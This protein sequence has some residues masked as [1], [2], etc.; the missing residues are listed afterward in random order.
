MSKHSTGHKPRRRGSSD[1]ALNTIM[2][3][4]IVA[5]L[6]LGVWAVSGKVAS[7]LANKTD[8]TDT[9][10]QQQT[11][12]TAADAEGKTVAEFL[13]EY[14]LDAQLPAETAMQDVYPTMTVENVAKMNQLSTEEFLEQYGLN[15]KVDGAANWGE[16]QNSIPVGKY[17]GS[18][19]TWQTVKSTYGLSDDISS[20]TPFSEV[21]PLLEA[22][23]AQQAEAAAQA[24]AAPQESAPAASEAPTATPAN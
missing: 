18:E 21:E 7:N 20:D 5:V 22:A 12:Q 9:S 24:S 14:G 23:A 4:V 2:V 1:F 3:V 11:V 10:T 13:S 15:G 19:E 17:F 8:S 16:A 6:G